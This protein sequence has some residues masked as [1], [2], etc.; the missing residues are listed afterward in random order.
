MDL[1]RYKLAQGRTAW[2]QL[3]AAV[4]SQQDRNYPASA[5]VLKNMNMP[6]GALATRSW[7]IIML[8]SCIAQSNGTRNCGELDYMQPQDRNETLF[9]KVLLDNFTEMAPIVYTPTVGWACLNYHKLYRRPR[10]MFFSANDKNEMVRQ[11]DVQTQLHVPVLKA[12]HFTMPHAAS[13]SAFLPEPSR[14]YQSSHAEQAILI[15]SLSSCAF[16]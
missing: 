8:A 5:L 6:Y 9:Y 12:G 15:V 4:S 3:T 10:G 2:R 13:V 16:K 14:Q 11:H 1:K 7:L